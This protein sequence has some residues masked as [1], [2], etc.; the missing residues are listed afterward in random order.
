MI[1]PVIENFIA[2][3]EEKDLRLFENRVF[4]SL[5]KSSARLN[6][7]NKWMFGLVV[8]YFLIVSPS[9][10]T[11][12][13]SLLGISINDLRLVGQAIPALI[14]ILFVF[15]VKQMFYR[16]DL[17]LSYKMAFARLSRTEFR[18]PA[19][20]SHGL[21][22]ITHLIIPYRPI[23]EIMNI[24]GRDKS[25]ISAIFKFLIT[26]MPI[27]VIQIVPLLFVVYGVCNNIMYNWDSL[28]G[29]SCTVLAVWGLLL[30]IYLFF[31][32]L[33]SSV[34]AGLKANQNSNSQ[35]L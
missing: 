34:L 10:E 15:Y 9:D 17:E 4:D 7:Y 8:I 2:A 21:D 13:I 25:C 16:N 22:Y 23:Y 3:A 14:A 24:K 32:T 26:G 6:L 18:S 11:T 1:N 5:S 27:L 30:G 31:T 33:I 20:N 12:T 19:E 29:R 35:I 28:Y